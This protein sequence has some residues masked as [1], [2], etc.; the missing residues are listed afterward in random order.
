MGRLS[1]CKC[2]GKKLKTEEKHQL[3]GKVYCEECFNRLHKEAE[4]Y[5][6]LMEFICTNYGLDEPTGLILKQV[7][8]YKNEYGYS[9]GAMTYTLWYCKE[10]L[11]KA[12]I[13][14]YGVSLIKYHYDDAK[15]YYSQ[16]EK[17]KEQMDKLS[18]V[19]IKTKIAKSISVPSNKKSTSL[20]NLDNLI[21]G[22]ESN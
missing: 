4:E 18:D 17:L 1:I 2:C 19:K 13:K 8:E 20:I 3:S 14:K 9:Y 5:K 11:N 12:F 16:Q 10:I 6:A 21:K 7:K 15:N 22:G